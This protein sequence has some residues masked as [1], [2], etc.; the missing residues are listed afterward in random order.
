MRMDALFCSTQC[1]DRAHALPRSLRSSGDKGGEIGFERLTIFERDG[2]Q[3]GHCGK[4]V[5][6][7]L[8]HPDPMCPSLDHIVPVSKGGATDSSNLRLVHLVCNLS[9]RNIGA[10]RAE[11][12]RR[13]LL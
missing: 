10:I 4:P 6:S 8:R 11:A 7:S 9:I 5:D 3:C 1:N 2:W 13:G 12:E